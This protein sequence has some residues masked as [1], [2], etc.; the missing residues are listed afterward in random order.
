MEVRERGENSISSAHHSYRMGLYRNVIFPPVALFLG[1]YSFILRDEI[2]QKS[3]V[4]V[5]A[6]CVQS[7]YL[8]LHL[9]INEKRPNGSIC[10][11][12]S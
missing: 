3:S 11:P 12:G 10:V 2:L 9:D 1:I 8:T 7:L 5:A 6:V 4:V